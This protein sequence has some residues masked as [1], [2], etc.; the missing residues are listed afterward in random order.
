MSQD[1]RDTKQVFKHW[2][3]MRIVK[4]MHADWHNALAKVCDELDIGFRPAELGDSQSNGAIEALNRRVREGARAQPSQAGLPACWWT[5]ATHRYCFLF[6][7]AKDAS[8]VSP[9]F[10]RYDKEFD[11]LWL[12]LGVGILYYPN[13][14][15]YK[16]Q[17]KFEPT[18]CYGIVVGYVPN[19]EPDRSGMYSVLGWDNFVNRSFGD[20]VAMGEFARMQHFTR[21]NKRGWNRK[22]SYSICCPSVEDPG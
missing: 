5:F 3:G 20:L 14:H 4:S 22:D 13:A 9:R 8:G 2:A 16:Y 1:T 11:G 18:L 17:L 7:T 10:K 21:P 6:N 12:P 15:K 19:P